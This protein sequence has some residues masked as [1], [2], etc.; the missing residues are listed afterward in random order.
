MAI[1][2]SVD[3]TAP[4]EVESLEEA[5]EEMYRL[6]WT[7][8]LPAIPPTDKLVQGVLDYLGRDP[9]EVVGPVPPKNRLATV[10]KIAVNCVMAGCLPEYVSFVPRCLCGKKRRNQG[11]V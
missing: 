11:V 5:H 9:Q 10:E 3:P 2:N 1:E 8:G 4:I 7:D 6:G